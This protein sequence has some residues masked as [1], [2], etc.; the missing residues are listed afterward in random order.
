MSFTN[1]WNAMWCTI[2]TMTTGMI[3]KTYFSIIIY[4]VVGY[5]DF[6][7]KTHFGR[8]ISFFCCIWGVFVVSLMVVT[9][10]NVLSMTPAEEKVIYTMNAK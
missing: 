4:F 2:L 7:A 8:L 9:L 3:F 10:N 6:Y 5:G 1:Y